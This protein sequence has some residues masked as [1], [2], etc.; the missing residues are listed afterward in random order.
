MPWTLNSLSLSRGKQFHQGGRTAADDDES[1]VLAPS[2]YPEL[3]KW[4]IEPTRDGRLSKFLQLYQDDTEAGMG[5]GAD[6]EACD[7]VLKSYAK[8]QRHSQRIAD[9]LGKGALEDVDENDAA[10]LSA[11]DTTSPSEVNIQTTLERNL[12]RQRNDDKQG[13][14]KAFLSRKGCL[15]A[16]VILL[17]LIVAGVVLIVRATKKNSLDP[18]SAGTPGSVAGIPETGSNS[19]VVVQKFPPVTFNQHHDFSWAPPSWQKAPP[20]PVWTQYFSRAVPNPKVSPDIFK[21]TVNIPKVWSAT[22]DDGPSPVTHIL[23]D[24]LKS[25]N[26]LTT[27]YVIGSVAVKHPQIMVDTFNAGHE[28]SIHTWS[29]QN[30][31]ATALADENQFI[32]ELV[33]GAK[34]IYDVLGVA[35]RYFRPPYGASGERVRRLAATMGLTSVSYLDSQDWMHYN[36]LAKLET[37]VPPNFRKWVSQS[38]THDITLQ[39]DV[40]EPEVV[41]AKEALDILLNAGYT[42]KPVFEC[43]GESSPYGNKILEGFFKSGQFETRDRVLPVYSS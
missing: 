36:E 27:F 9:M 34:V 35:P 20:V 15:C 42:L 38:R 5:G 10:F 26:V 33:Y 41:V 28:I 13:R 29:H 30:L 12:K 14:I 11:R 3:K 16:L 31:T 25:K 4:G 7:D 17:V 19:T 1:E 37:I 18:V 43:L 24:Y 40:W 23:T 39:H 8:Q 32:A 22:F 2:R 6:Y 21:C